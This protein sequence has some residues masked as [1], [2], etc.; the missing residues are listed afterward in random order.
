MG[1]SSSSWGYPKWAMDALCQGT[2][3]LAMDVPCCCR[4]LATMHCCRF[5]GPTKICHCQLP[6][7][8]AFWHRNHPLAITSKT[9]QFA[10]QQWPFQRRGFRLQRWHFREEHHKI[11]VFVPARPP[12]PSRWHSLW[13]KW[14][15]QV[16]PG[17]CLAA[18]DGEDLPGFNLTA[19]MNPNRNYFSG[20]PGTKTNRKSWE[21]RN[22][23]GLCQGKSQSK[24]D[25]EL[26]VALF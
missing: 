20:A 9:G 8:S 3:H 23:V 15:M 10:R 11:H 6:V 24:M 26:G 17:R 22:M 14:Q 18:G 16:R 5:R 2:S 4:L 19:V 21:M 12:T 7:G 13:P 25:D 1:I